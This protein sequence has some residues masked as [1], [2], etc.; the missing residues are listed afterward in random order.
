MKDNQIVERSLTRFRAGQP[1]HAR[2]TMDA[3]DIAQHDYIGHRDVVRLYFRYGN[4]QLAHV[5]YADIKDPP[6]QQIIEAWE[7]LKRVRLSSKIDL[8]TLCYE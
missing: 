1:F 2:Q 4:G 7:D 6:K 3:M 5:Y 8:L